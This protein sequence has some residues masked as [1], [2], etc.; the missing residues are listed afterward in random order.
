MLVEVGQSGA[1][2]FEIGL[3]DL[4][5]GYTAVHLQA[6]CCGHQ[7]SEGGLQAGFA[8]LDVVELLRSEV[9]AEARFGND[10]VGVRHRH[11]R[12]HNGVAAVGDV[13][14]GAAV[15]ERGGVLCGLHEVRFE[16]IFEEHHDTARHAEILHRE[17]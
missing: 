8:A 15:Y 10:V 3:R 12:G 16:R 11:F 7:H 2:S 6:L 9:G 13:G 5:E 1:K 17:G 14:K 4:V